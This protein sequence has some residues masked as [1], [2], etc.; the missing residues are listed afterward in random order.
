MATNTAKCPE[1]NVNEWVF[2][3]PR[4]TMSGSIAVYVDT[5][6]DNASNPKF[7]LPPSVAPFGI[8]QTDHNGNV[9]PCNR[10][11]NMELDI[12]RDDV[13]ALFKLIDNR[14]IG[15]AAANSEKWFKKSFNEDDLR[16]M[17]YRT[18]VQENKNAAYKPKLRVKI[19]PGNQQTDRRATKIYIVQSDGSYKTNGEMVDVTPGSR[20]Q[21]IIEVGSVWFASNQF[22]ISLVARHILVWPKDAADDDFPFSNTGLQKTPSKNMTNIPESSKLDDDMIIEKMVDDTRFV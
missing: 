12:S 16:R 21:C 17:M 13:K 19:T 10:R 9:L 20:V 5:S 8:S 1:V 3:K 6:A 22:G 14:V 2:Q 15:A 11:R 7:E 4:Q 18:S